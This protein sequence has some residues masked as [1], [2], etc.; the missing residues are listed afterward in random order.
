MA[1]RPDDEDRGDED[2]ED[3]ADPVAAKEVPGG[4]DRKIAQL[5]PGEAG[6]EADLPFAGKY[7]LGLVREVESD[8]PFE[9]QAPI[10]VLWPGGSPY[11]NIVI[12]EANDRQKIVLELSQAA[13]DAAASE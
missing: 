13:L 2:H 5:K 1:H 4:T 10:P 3:G 12:D 11:I 9:T 7:M 8:D 6:W